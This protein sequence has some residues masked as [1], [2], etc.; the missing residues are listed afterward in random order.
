MA[1]MILFGCLAFWGA[2]SVVW[3]VLGWLL[4]KA[5][6]IL[7]YRCPHT[8]HPDGAIVRYCW[9]RSLG[10]VHGPLVI[11][12]SCSETEQ[13]M[14]AGTYPGVEFCSPEDLPAR[15]ELERMT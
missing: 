13:E 6:L 5:P 9:L 1:L 8:H 15:L 11:V 12:G 2:V 3:T 10:F 4:P 7:L 14:L